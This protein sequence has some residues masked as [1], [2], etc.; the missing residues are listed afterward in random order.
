MGGRLTAQ[1]RHPGR[2]LTEKRGAPNVVFKRRRRPPATMRLAR[3][4]LIFV[5]LNI[6][7]GRRLAF[8]R[9]LPSRGLQRFSTREGAQHATC[10]L[11]GTDQGLE[12]GTEEFARRR[13]GGDEGMSSMLAPV[14]PIRFAMTA[15]ISRNTELTAGVACKSPFTRIP[16]EMIKSE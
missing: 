5:A 1:V 10:E 9:A 2:R 6:T 11:A 15:P 8:K 4:G 14:V 13:A 3:L 7:R 12:R 16:P